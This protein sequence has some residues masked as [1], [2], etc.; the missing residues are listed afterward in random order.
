MRKKIGVIGA[1]ISGLTCAYEL[2]KQGFEVQVFEKEAHVGGRAATIQTGGMFLD[3]GAIVFSGAEKLL[4]QIIEEFGIDTYTLNQTKV[5]FLNKCKIDYL[6][7]SS[8]FTSLLKTTRSPLNLLKAIW[9]IVQTMAQRKKFGSVN[10]L[11]KG[12]LELA[13]MN[14]REYLSEHLGLDLG[15]QF[16]E[17]LLCGAFFQSL[18]EV[19]ALFMMNQLYFT[20]E[21]SQKKGSF[22]SNRLSEGIGSISKKLSE[23][24][25][26]KTGYAIS[27][28]KSSQVKSSQVKSSQVIGAD[29]DHFFDAL[30]LAIP[31]PLAKKIYENPTELQKK[32]LDS[33]IYGSTMTLFFF[34]PADLS[35]WD[36]PIFCNEEGSEKI[37]CISS[38]AFTDKTEKF[39]KNGKGIFSVYLQDKYAKKIM[40]LPDEEV[41]SLIKTEL[42]NIFPQFKGRLNEIENVWLHRW[43]HAFAKYQ[44]E[45]V[46][47]VTSFWENGQGDNRVY[48]CGDYLNHPCTDGAAMCG[49][50]VADL[51]TAKFK[52]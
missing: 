1:G 5:G 52:E 41:Y 11:S 46:P 31:A 10:D 47:L 48:L 37:S 29:Q 49:K 9:F 28:V 40:H 50:K 42:V 33:A 36:A 17:P 16:V 6:P 35:V 14:G 19:S 7:H 44:P 43:E 2:Q 18:V 4:P 13:K 32:V 34:L 25:S 8:L 22:A 38:N 26:V 51:I 45:S 23:N 3:P 30:V 24:L 21:K 39:I 15:R 20:F 12:D 27:K